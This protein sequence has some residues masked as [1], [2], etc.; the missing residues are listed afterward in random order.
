[1]GKAYKALQAKVT[2]AFGNPV[3]GVKVT[4]TAPATGAGGTFGGKATATALSGANGVASA[5]TFTA[6]TRAGGFTV[7]ASVA[8][9]GTPALFSLT[10]KPGP[11]ARIVPATG[12]T[13]QTAS[14]NADFAVALAVN[15]TDSFGN[16]LSNVTVTFTVKPDVK[17]G[18]G[19]TFTG[20]GHVVTE[21]TDAT[22]LATAP[23]LTADG[24]AGTFTVVASVLGVAIKGTF[25]LTIS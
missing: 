6:N 15:V 19:A 16:A 4:F 8:G 12:T 3:G 20:G 22:G 25:R 13:P 10:N 17:T 21:P 1:V 18:A 9:V 23:A 5:P 14:K 11:V 2:D 24:S 7:S